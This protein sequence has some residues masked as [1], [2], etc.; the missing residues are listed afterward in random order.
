MLTVDGSEYTIMQINAMLTKTE[1]VV[2]VSV[3][4]ICDFG[5]RLLTLKTRNL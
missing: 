4:R 1:Q 3:S 2:P 5:S